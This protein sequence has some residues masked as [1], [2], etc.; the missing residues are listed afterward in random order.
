MRDWGRHQERFIWLHST[1]EIYL[2]CL[3]EREIQNLRCPLVHYK[4]WM[5]STCRLPKTHFLEI[6]P[7]P[8][9]LSLSLTPVAM[10]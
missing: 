7:E 10:A 2:K 5:R 4:M 1:Y 3:R 8:T 6:S 9:I